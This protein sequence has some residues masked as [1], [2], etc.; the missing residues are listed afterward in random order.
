MIKMT[1]EKILLETEEHIVTS[2]ISSPT[3]VVFLLSNGS[4]FRYN[5]STKKEEELF[6]VYTSMSYTDGGFDLESSSTLY[7]LD[8]IVVLANDYKFHAIVHYPGKYKNLRLQRK[9]YY[10]EISK[11]PIALFKDDRGVPHIIYGVDWNHVQ[12][13]NLSTRQLLTAAKSLIKVD[14]EEQYVE[15]YKTHEE[16][17]FCDDIWPYSY[18]YF[19][20]ELSMSPN[21]QYFLSAGWVWGSADSHNIYEVE[22]FINNSRIKD[23]N[24][25][26]WEHENR[27][28]CWVSNTCVAVA[29]NPA[30]EWENDAVEGAP[31]EIHLYQIADE[32]T[33][34]KKLPIPKVDLAKVAFRYSQQLKALV[35][36]SENLGVCIINLK[37]EILFKDLD[38]K[39][40]SYNT[41][42]EMGIE[43]KENCIN[44]IRFS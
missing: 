2:C 27:A 22:H 41:Q 31:C 6:S 38:L 8:N 9:D 36:Y 26:M 12:I 25:N 28:S 13:L 30:T 23:Q 21:N 44:I 3:E 33:L 10:A 39:M 16:G 4:V 43:S 37:G 18:N 42:Y 1:Q 19:F 11:Y 40:D 34:Q 15:F 7:T 29:Y 5:T 32:I 14:A 24:I 35:I 20:G 17:K